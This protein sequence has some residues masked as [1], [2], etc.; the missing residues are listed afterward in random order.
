VVP[1]RFFN[2]LLPK[3]FEINCS[4]S[5]TDVLKEMQGMLCS[6][7]LHWNSYHWQV[8]SIPDRDALEAG[9]GEELEMAPL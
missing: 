6:A 7:P 3:I 8:Q 1:H 5:F 4:S 9:E 2:F